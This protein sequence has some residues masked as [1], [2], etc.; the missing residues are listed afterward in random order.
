VESDPWGQPYKIVLHKLRLSTSPL[1]ENIDSDTLDN[2][3]GTLFPKQDNCPGEPE[4]FHSLTPSDSEGEGVAATSEWKDEYYITDEEL[5]MAVKRMTSRDVA[6]GPDGVPGR[7]WAET[8]N[9]MAPRLRHLFNRY[10]REGVYPR[11]WRIMRLVL[12]RKEGRPLDSPSGYRP[13]CLLD[14]EGKLL[15]E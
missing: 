2:I 4:P 10:M 12:L 11:I 1:N 7:I 9:I 3:V 6:P 13:I 15:E 8:I 14:E 5:M